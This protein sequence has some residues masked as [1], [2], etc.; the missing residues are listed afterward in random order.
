VRVGELK[1][2]EGT[3]GAVKSLE[4][5]LVSAQHVFQPRVPEKKVM[6][7]ERT[8]KYGLVLVV[9]Q[10]HRQPYNADVALGASQH[11]FEICD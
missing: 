11:L 4:V 10:I 5:E 9:Q 8:G 3:T 7:V 2:H 1:R 6:K